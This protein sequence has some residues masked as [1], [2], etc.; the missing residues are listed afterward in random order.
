MTWQ[1]LAATC[2]ATLMLIANAT[3]A[4]ADDGTSAKIESPTTVLPARPEPDPVPAQKP[5]SAASPRLTAPGCVVPM[6]GRYA[7]VD[8]APADKG[9][10]QRLQANLGTVGQSPNAII[11]TPQW[12]SSTTITG[13]RTAACVTWQITYTTYVVTNGVTQVT[14]VLLLDAYSYT[15]TAVG[16][17]NFNHQIQLASTSGWGDAL[18]ASLNGAGRASGACTLTATS[19]P[20]QPATPFRVMR[21]GEAGFNTTATAAGAIGRCATTWDVNFI[22]PGY[23]DGHIT[24]TLNEV[25]C[26][27][28]VGANLQRPRRV[29][30][31]I[32]WYASTAWYDRGAYPSLASHV[33]R[34]QASGLPGGPNNAQVP[35][36]RTT[37]TTIINNNRNRACG[38]AP[39]IAGKSCDEYPLASTHQGLNAGGTRRT[40]SGCSIN[41]PTNVTGPSG[42]SACMITA[43]ENNAQGALMAAFYYDWRVLN[44]DPMRVGTY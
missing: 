8:V 15:Y 44:D 43:S 14:G 21:S 38:D 40:F 24:H 31:V 33:E 32:A 20:L 10:G 28:A 41:A 35:L 22:T 13:L 17:P 18:K 42:A 30:C 25:R 27:N 37:N 26:D 23:T 5:A 3:P 1:R 19:F 2:M 11:P 7:C 39:S 29:G 12:C 6:S 36:T 4:D 34:A 9:A 16:L